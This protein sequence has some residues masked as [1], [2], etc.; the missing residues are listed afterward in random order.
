M[1]TSSVKIA[2]WIFNAN[3]FLNWS[4]GE[5]W[6]PIPAEK[7]N[8]RAVIKAAGD[9][10][11]DNWG[12]VSLPVPHGTPCARLEGGLY[13]GSKNLTANTCDMG[14]FPTPLTVGNRRYVIDE[15]FGAVSILN[16]FPFLEASF[17]VDKVT[18]SSNLFRVQGGF[19]RY[20]HEVTVCATKNCSR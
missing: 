6:D 14:A 19:I 18:P 10:Y 8:S 9:A 16:D 11:L 3:L 5:S 13:T 17:P 7:Q 20:I 2:H 4:K 12:N 1:A 15:E